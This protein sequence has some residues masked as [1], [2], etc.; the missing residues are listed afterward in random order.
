ML[1]NRCTATKH[2]ESAGV[3]VAVAEKCQYLQTILWGAGEDGHAAAAAAAA[4]AA[5]NG[6]DGSSAAAA[7]AAAAASQGSQV[8]SHFVPLH[9]SA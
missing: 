7:A 4:A 8:I 1:L 3:E 6:L 2:F 5:S 9:L